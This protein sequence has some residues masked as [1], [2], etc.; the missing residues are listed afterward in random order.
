V[1]RALLQLFTGVLLSLH[2]LCGLLRLELLDH[3]RLYRY[4]LFLRSCY[5]AHV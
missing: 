5:D 4:L 3:V 2:L 1:V